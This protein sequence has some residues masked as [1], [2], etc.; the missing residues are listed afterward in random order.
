MENKYKKDPTTQD[1]LT[2]LETW[3]CEFE[4]SECDGFSVRSP[5]G[6]ATRLENPDYASAVMEAWTLM[7]P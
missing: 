6:G 1:M 7:K 3:G 2:D 5:K 4:G